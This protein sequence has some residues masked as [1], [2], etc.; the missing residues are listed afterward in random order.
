MNHQSRKICVMFAALIAG[1]M[2]FAAGA[3]ADDDPVVD[4]AAGVT[5]PI[6]TAA[7]V[8]K[9]VQAVAA[10]VNM[11]YVVA[12]TDRQGD[13]LAVYTKPNAPALS[14]GNFGVLA[15]TKDVAIALARTA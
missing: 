13:V 12:V 3:F 15:D 8:D 10:A 2:T 6:L 7:D 11:P 9:V 1:L 14:K 4:P 5:G